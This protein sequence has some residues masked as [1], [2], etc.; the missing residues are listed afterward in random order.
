MSTQRR[1]H[2][3]KRE[4]AEAKVTELEATLD[5]YRRDYVPSSNWRR[6]RS[7]VNGMDNLRREISRYR[8]LAQRYAASGE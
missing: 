2:R 3:T 1:R 6:V 4:W 5:S 7:K 8:Q